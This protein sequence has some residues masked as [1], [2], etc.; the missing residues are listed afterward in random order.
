M[1]QPVMLSTKRCGDRKSIW[2]LGHLPALV[3]VGKMSMRC[4]AHLMKVHIVHRG[5]VSH[6]WMQA[7]REWTTLAFPPSA[8]GE[9][10]LGSKQ[11][12]AARVWSHPGC[13]CDH[14]WICASKTGLPVVRD[15]QEVG[16]KPRT[17]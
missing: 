3:G 4:F 10:V 14:G 15:P 13:C 16:W 8:P 1:T 6:V 2:E 17:F 12:N 9:V 7:G 5:F 11:L